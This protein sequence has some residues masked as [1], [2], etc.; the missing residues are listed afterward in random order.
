MPKQITIAGP[1]LGFDIDSISLA[2][3]FEGKWLRL[4]ASPL[5]QCHWVVR[6]TLGYTR[7]LNPN[8]H[9]HNIKRSQGLR[10]IFQ[11]VRSLRALVKRHNV[12]L[13][14]FHS[15]QGGAPTAVLL[16]AAGIRVPFLFQ[17]HHIEEPTK[18]YQSRVKQLAKLGAHFV[19]PSNSASH[20]LEALGVPSAQ[21]SMLP[22]V[23]FNWQPE[24]ANIALASAAEADYDLVYTGSLTARKRPELILSVAA[25]LQKRTSRRRI[26][27]AI[28]GQG[29]LLE[30]LQKLAASAN[31]Q[32]DFFTGCSEKM[33]WDILRRSRIFFTA[34]EHEG[35]G[36]GAL[37]AALA[38]LWVIGPDSGALPET[39]S[40]LDHTVCIGAEA[41]H[42]AYLASVCQERLKAAPQPVSTALVARWSDEGRWRADHEKLLFQLAQ[43]RIDRKL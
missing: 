30:K 39:L 29:D 2:E 3:R 28:V 9:F 23:L 6:S 13:V 25:E 4:L 33:K 16:R 41:F 18:K 12:E 8:H 14:R 36:Y 42:P 37:E 40:G 1:H 31:L 32:V 11:E 43:G 24:Y 34:S 5:V 21:T 7:D 20:E 17:H 38:G 22:G 26:E 27:V 19:C 15:V 10:R 35:F